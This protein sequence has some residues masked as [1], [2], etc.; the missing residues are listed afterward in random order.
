M[1][2]LL[3]SGK[4]YDAFWRNSQPFQRNVLPVVMYRC[5]TWSLTLREERKLRAFENMVVRRI[6]GPK[7]DEVAGE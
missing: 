7:R 1:R 4:K 2:D 6:F 5:E 3:H